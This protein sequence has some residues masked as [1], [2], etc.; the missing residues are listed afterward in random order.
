MPT[1]INKNNLRDL[2]TT[3]DNVKVER[4]VEKTDNTLQSV[5]RIAGKI[6]NIMSL[7]GKFKE[8][9]LPQEKAPQTFNNIAPKIEAGINKGMEETII[10]IKNSAKIKIDFKGV[11]ETINNFLIALDE[12]K[13]VKEL[14]TE[15]K[16]LKDLEMLEK[17]ITDLILNNC[18]VFYNG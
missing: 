8:K 16:Q 11:E 3:S 2:G 5:E 14:K 9:G 4:V 1:D 10:K 18:E 6:E 7:L 12:K 13:T 17:I 15:F